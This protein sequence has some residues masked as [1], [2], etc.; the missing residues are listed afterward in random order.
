MEFKAL[1]KEGVVWRVGNGSH[2]RIWDDPWVMG[3]EGRFLTS[4]RV[5]GLEMVEESIDFG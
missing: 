2:I 1:I 3:E 5:L 4:P